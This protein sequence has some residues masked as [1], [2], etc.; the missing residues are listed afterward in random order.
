[1]TQQEINILAN[2]IRKHGNN[3][4]VLIA[5]IASRLIPKS[6]QLAFKVVSGYSKG[7]L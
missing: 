3:K 5:D 1:M 6:H 7:D 2:S 4:D